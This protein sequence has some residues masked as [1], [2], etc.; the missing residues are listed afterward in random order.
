MENDKSQFVVRIS[1]FYLSLFICH[2]LSFVIRAIHL[3]QPAPRDCVLVSEPNVA[4]STCT[5]EAAEQLTRRRRPARV[6]AP[7]ASSWGWLSHVDSPICHWSFVI[8]HLSLVICH[9]SFSF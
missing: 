5:R 3:T 6:T 4:E 9:W 7:I 8:G 2:Y 1:D